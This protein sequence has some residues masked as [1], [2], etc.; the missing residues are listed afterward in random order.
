MSQVDAR[1]ERLFGCNPTAILVLAR[2]FP[3]ELML[4]I[5]QE[6]NLAETVFPKP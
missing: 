1:T 3:D 6:N 5:A 4:A 2:W